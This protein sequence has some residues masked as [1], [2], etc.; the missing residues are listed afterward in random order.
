MDVRADGVERGPF[1]D[2]VLRLTDAG[3]R[4]GAGTLAG[5]TAGPDGSRLVPLSNGAASFQYTPPANAA[6]DLLHVS[7]ENGEGAAGDEIGQLPLRVR[8]A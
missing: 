8:T 3:G 1:G 7:F 6:V 4:P 2:V 5:G